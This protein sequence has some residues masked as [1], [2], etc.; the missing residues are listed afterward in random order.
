MNYIRVFASKSCSHCQKL[1]QVLSNIDVK[2]VYVDAMDE[3]NSVLCDKYNIEKLPHVQFIDKN[4]NKIVKE[5]F[6]VWDDSTLKEVSNLASN[7]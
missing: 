3:K 6:G 5:Y 2:I 7:F 4:K 1:K